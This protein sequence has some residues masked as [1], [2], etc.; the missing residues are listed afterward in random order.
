[1]TQ[2]GPRELDP[3]V[4]RVYLVR[5]G[6]T[7]WNQAD[8]YQG[9][10]DVPLS[11][12]G[13]RQIAELAATLQPVPFAAVYTSPLCRA[14][15]TAAAIA[16]GRA[17]PITPVAELRELSYG[18]CQGVPPSERDAELD[19]LWR[20]EP[21]RVRFP[22]GESL[23]D[24]A[25]RAWPAF[26]ALAARHRGE[27]IVVSGHGHLNRVLILRALRAPIERFW[28]VDQPNAAC[29]VLDLDVPTATDATV[30]ARSSHVIR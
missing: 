6:E 24:V 20:A 21:W 18:R 25:T 23:D 1:V 13:R 26:L 22:E 14:S 30:V 10:A 29:W 9:T 16:L 3:L 12:T 11:D 15:D 8:I 4:T 2:T 19:R 28:S 17:V 5:H 27:T 7:S